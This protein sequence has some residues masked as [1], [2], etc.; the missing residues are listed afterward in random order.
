MADRF[1]SRTWT[2]RPRNASNEGIHNDAAAQRLGFRGA[3][4]PG[5]TLYEN[6]VVGL[7][8]QDAAWLSHGRTEMNFRR[9]VYD[10][11]EMTFTINSETQGWQLAS[12]GEPRP[13]AYGVLQFDSEPP[14]IPTGQ[15]VPK[16]G[17]PLGDP[18]QVG[19]L[20]ESAV[21]F[22][23][24]RMEAAAKASGFPLSG[25]PRVVPA[26]LWTNPVDM[27]HAYFDCPVT[28]HLTSRIWHQSPLLEHE[29]LQKRGQIIGFEERNGNRIVHFNAELTAS[30]RPIATIAHS[31]VYRMR[32]ARE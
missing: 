25:S 1:T 11:D 18:A 22:P 14:L 23:A 8:T 28:I 17:K 16:D 29:I 26:G 20:M 7:L 15:L 9:P 3:F 5:V 10:V 32:D 31:S 27:L 21:E 6:L 24:E 4:V 2:V 12:E 13:R 19:A 30:G